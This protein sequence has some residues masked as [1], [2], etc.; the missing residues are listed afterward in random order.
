[1]TAEEF[2]TRLEAIFT[3]ILKHFSHVLPGV[4][5][6]HIVQWLMTRK[7]PWE[8]VPA[9]V[10]ETLG[11]VYNSLFDL[12]DPIVYVLLLKWDHKKTKS[13]ADLNLATEI[14]SEAETYFKKNHEPEIQRPELHRR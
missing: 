10:Q 13:T 2:N 8:S 12:P 11:R 7:D 5:I 4:I 9:S 14:L 6:E 1:M 3:D